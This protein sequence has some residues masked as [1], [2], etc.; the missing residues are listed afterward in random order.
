MDSSRPRPP[1]LRR[2]RTAIRLCALCMMLPAVVFLL[3]YL[4]NLYSR[5]W[6]RSRFWQDV[7]ELSNGLLVMF[8]ATTFAML[9]VAFANPLSRLFSPRRRYRICPRCAYPIALHARVRRCPECGMLQPKWSDAP[10]FDLAYSRDLFREVQ[11]TRGLNRLLLVG[12]VFSIVGLIPI[13]WMLYEVLHGLATARTARISRSSWLLAYY[14]FPPGLLAM[15]WGLLAQN[16]ARAAMRDM[17]AVDRYALL[18]E[19]T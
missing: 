8:I 14:F 7:S 1:V 5:P 4:L 9:A 6:L 2:L 17:K 10:T 13:A 15:S 16:R 11:M 19:R 18:S 3:P 12:I